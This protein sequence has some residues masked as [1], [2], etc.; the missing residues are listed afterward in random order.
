LVAGERVK[1]IRR[2]VLDWKTGT[3]LEQDSYD[4]EGPI[5]C[6]KSSGSAP[7][8][9]DPYQQASAQ[10]GLST[11]TALFN[12]GLNRTNTENPLGSSTWNAYYPGQ[13]STTPAPGTPTGPNTVQPQPQPQPSSGQYQPPLNSGGL[14]S[15]SPYGAYGN[16]LQ[17][18]GSSLGLPAT[19]T[20]GSPYNG[21]PSGSPYGGAPTYTQD[22]AL[23]P[24]FQNALQAPIDTSGILSPSQIASEYQTSQQPVSTAGVI[25]APGGPSTMGARD[26]IQNALYQQQSQ[27]LDPQFAQS[28]EQLGSQLS[29][30][31][32][33]P[34]SAA[35]KNAMDQQ[36]RNKTFSYNSAA[37]SAIT[38]ATGQE[39]T[40]QGI[41][42]GG[43]NADIAARSAPITE[44]QA[45]QGMGVSGLNA[46]I[47]ARNAPINEF[48]SLLGTGGGSATAQTP[49]ISGAFGQQ[50]QGAL[51][52][53]NAQNASNNQTT[54]DVTSLIAMGLLYA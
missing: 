14:G 34:G 6:A 7:A 9:V 16:V 24:Q 41:G 30:Q 1:I 21:S 36:N 43:L 53:Y 3:V 15:V 49:D 10:Y 42:V 50:Y 8:P 45:L 20:A 19:G 18:G 54:S 25:G 26:Q 40:L 11:G 13:N 47:S 17:T 33:M 28:D 35:Y 38:G 39:S 51:A 23:A 37:N 2:A 32:I 4:Y 12:A 5:A 46:N 52:G 31:G 27:Y 22:T 29:A 44:Q 48:E